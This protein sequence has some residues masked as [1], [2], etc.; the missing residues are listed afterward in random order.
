MRMAGCTLALLSLGL[1]PGC[2]GGGG[3]SAP[4][5]PPVTTIS[6]VPSA[7]AAGES[8]VLTW[9]SSGASQCSS[10]GAWTGT[11][12]AAGSQNVTQVAAGLYSYTLTCSGAGGSTANSATLT[13]SAPTPIVSI[14]LSPSTISTDHTATL[15]WSASNASSCA[16]SGAW[17]GLQPV[18]GSTTV[19][20]LIPGN[21]TYA[22]SCSNGPQQTAG[23]STVLTVV[24]PQQLT[25][26]LTAN[27]TSIA[28]GQ[29]TILTWTSDGADTCVASGAWSGTLPAS[30]SQSVSVSA[31]GSNYY[32][33]QCA[34][35]TGDGSAQAAV[36]GVVATVSLTASPTT[37]GVGQP[38]T[39]TWSSTQANSCT[40]SG[41]WSGALASS[42]SQVVKPGSVGSHSYSLTCGNPGAPAQASVVVTGSIPVVTLSAFP[43]SVAQG[44]TV[45]LRWNGQYA[46][47]CVASGAWSGSLSSTGKMTLTPAT[48]GTENFHLACA[49]AALSVPADA[50]VTVLAAPA[51]PPATAYR[52]TERHDGVLI[53]SNGISYPANTAPTWTVDLGAAPSYPLIAGGMVFVAT[54]NPDGSYGNRLYGLNATTGATVWGPV[55]IPGVYFGSGLT[56]D[57]G[58]VFL[59]MFDGGIRAF[60]ASNGAALWTT[61]LPGYWYEASPNA[62]GGS[63]F[64]IGNGGLSAVDEAS[65]NILWTTIS[66]A[67]TDWNSPGISSEGAYTQSGN[68]V[69]G[70]YDP[71]VGTQLWLV[72]S[73]CSASF[74][75]ASII[76]NDTLFGRTGASLNLFDST[77][78]N[79]KGQIASASAPAVTSTAVITLNA[80]T[81]SSTRLTDLAQTWTFVGDGHLQT[82]PI[83]VNNTVLIGSGSGNVY[84]VD[85][86]TGSQVWVGVSPQPINVDSESGGPMPPA[87]PAAGENLL[88]FLTAHGLV[89]WQ[90]Q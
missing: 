26:A 7:I 5:A 22:L 58:R 1:V 12:A 53:T 16:A 36:Q 43:T 31:P 27:P 3:S 47:S 87:G 75:F 88:V 41:E 83:V 25:T 69:A 38:T 30:G 24:F 64:I 54:A 4:P 32:F 86:G 71:S 46:D 77:T 90:F 84:G 61:Q 11:V 39:L 44:K 62:Y 79:Q 81:L 51:S 35:A 67:S 18:T 68:C 85:A 82:A 73:Q 63:V 9:S 65:G 17:S 89:A 14:S 8:S 50:S 19:G 80:G 6:L 15:T 13:V 28:V 29:S 34:S 66:S 45:T 42:G 10:S 49:N 60:N 76:K 20:Q 55:A 52:V 23:N 57:N 72:Q 70:A 56:Y 2:G 59:L 78:G 40:A 21:Y 33:L 74:G 37:T 48:Q